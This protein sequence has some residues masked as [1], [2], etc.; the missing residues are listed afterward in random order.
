LNCNTLVMGPGMIE[1]VKVLL[2]GSANAHC[3]RV[4]AAL[5]AAGEAVRLHTERCEPALL[6]GWPAD[7]IVSYNHRFLLP[8]AVYS[9][10]RLG[11]INLHIAYLP[12]NRG[13]DPNFWSHAE[14]TPKG[15]SIHRID[16]GLDTG[17]LVARE[18][19]EFSDADTL[20]TSYETLHARLQALLLT[21]WPLIRWGRAPRAPQDPGGTLHRKGEREAFA[22]VLAARGWDTP[23]SEVAALRLDHET[24]HGRRE[25]GNRV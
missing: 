13:A 17:A 1:R 21:W 3:E 2:L 18:A 14:H 23:I 5:A 25:H 15:V 11:A 8:E 10:P 7:I 19:V 20:R 16:A 6:A 9:A 22:A 12:W 4:R 24:I